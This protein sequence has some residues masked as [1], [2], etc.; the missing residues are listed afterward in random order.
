[1]SEV[2]L[3]TPSS[4]ETPPVSLE[5]FLYAIRELGQ[6]DFEQKIVLSRRALLLAKDQPVI[7][8]ELHYHLGRSYYFL[9][10]YTQAALYLHEALGYYEVQ[11]D[12]GFQ[13][14]VLLSLGAMYQELGDMK[15]A[16]EYLE[17]SLGMYGRL[18]D[19]GGEVRVLRS[20][21]SLQWRLGDFSGALAFY[22]EAFARNAQR[23][24]APPGD[25]ARLH[26]SLA[27]ALTSLGKKETNAA[28]LEQALRHSQQAT[29]LHEGLDLPWDLLNI[30]QGRLELL[31]ALGYLTEAES[32]F[33]EVSQL[34]K[35]LSDQRSEADCLSLMGDM[36][37]AMQH[38]SRAVIFYNEALGFYEHLGVKDYARFEAHHKLA[39][40][41]EQL[42]DYKTA[43]HHHKRFHA[44][45]SAYKTEA[46]LKKAQRLSAKFNL[47]KAQLSAEMHRLKTEELE[48]LVAERTQQL[49]SAHVDMLERL[50]V[51]AEFRDDTTGGHTVRVGELAATMA[52]RL[53]LDEETITQLRLAARLHDIGK[54]SIPDDILLKAGRLSTE[55]WESMKTHAAIGAQ[56]LSGGDGILEL[57]KEIALTHHERWDGSGYPHAL[58]GEA[59]PLSG[60]ILAIADVYDALIHE[61]PYKK[62]WSKDQ[63]VA[64]I[65]AQSGKHF[66]PNVVEVFLEIISDTDSEKVLQTPT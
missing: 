42:G 13:A 53:G 51:V 56:M 34:A 18:A 9:S 41:L 12:S 4:L 60:R 33:P 61:R 50:A 31:I 21:G 22:R 27:V 35:A 45:E 25:T 38:P 8:A 11:G 36:Y 55:E 3:T 20:L 2:L 30:Q 19:L 17:R 7:L 40:V 43:L 54:I 37:A 28:Y 29:D 57:A 59:I 66:D 5:N 6:Q 48:A 1:M 44:L 10:E 65:R 62:A 39:E 58:K 23:P 26:A 46:A 64:E 32:F 15:E 24:D 49:E 63:A 47:E 14:A 52:Q 16:A